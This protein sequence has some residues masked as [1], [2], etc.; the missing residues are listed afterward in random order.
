VVDALRRLVDAGMGV[1][2]LTRERAEQLV[3]DLSRRGE[4]AGE[5][6]ES[7]VRQLVER[8]QSE[9]AA[10][11]AFIA[12]RVAWALRHQPLATRD[13]LAALEQRLMAQIRAATGARDGTAGSG[14]GR[15][16]EGGA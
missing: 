3:D 4:L 6:R 10:L 5:D 8:G 1:Y 14:G 15:D 13:D 2:S 12:D 11:E 16:G 9:R 7:L